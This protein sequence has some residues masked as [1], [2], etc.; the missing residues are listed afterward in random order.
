MKKLQRTDVCTNTF[1]H[2]SMSQKQTGKNWV[3]AMSHLTGTSSEL[4]TSEHKNVEY[5]EKF[6]I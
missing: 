6:Y 5:L 1:L 2:V 3:A 4:F